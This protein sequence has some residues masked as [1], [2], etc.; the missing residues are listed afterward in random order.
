MIKPIS[1]QEISDTIKT[2]KNNK[3]PGMDGFPGEFYK[4]FVEEIIPVLSSF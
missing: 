2:L 4:C 1:L 3:S